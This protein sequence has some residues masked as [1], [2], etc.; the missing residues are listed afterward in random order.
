MKALKKIQVIEK[1]LHEINQK[2]LLDYTG[3]FEMIGKLSIGDQIRETHIR[4]R[5][6]TEY[7][8]YIN[9][10]IEGYDAGDAFF[11]GY[12]YKTNTA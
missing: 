2:I 5:N 6:I 11:N 1:K 3:D 9:S 10:I 12:I 8:A 7:E 4:F